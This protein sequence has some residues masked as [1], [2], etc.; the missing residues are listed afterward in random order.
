MN[1]VFMTLI[2]PTTHVELAR[3]I[4]ATLESGGLGMFTTPLSPTGGDPITHYISTGYVPGTWHPIVPMKEWTMNMDGQWELV[5]TTTGDIPRLLELCA[6]KELVVSQEEVDALF[7]A[8]D[9]T[10]QDPFVAMQ[11]LGIMLIT[12]SVEEM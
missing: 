11:R 1:D 8:A 5:N 3:T 6:E 2:I 7:T 12:P 10:A 4:A 9:I